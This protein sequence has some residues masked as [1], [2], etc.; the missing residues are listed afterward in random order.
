MSDKCAVL[1]KYYE[2]WQTGQF[3]E[4]IFADNFTFNGPIAKAGDKASFLAMVKEMG[5]MVTVE[6]IEFKARFMNDDGDKA[7]A[8]Y[9][10]VTSKP[11][12]ASTPCSE[13]F[14]LEDGKI[15]GIELIY[16]AREWEK[17]MS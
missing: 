3:D 13:Y 8:L 9:N 15:T 17:A 1:K 7:C 2:G 16:D 12:K 10:F 14:T 4:T 5:D 6:N 11:I